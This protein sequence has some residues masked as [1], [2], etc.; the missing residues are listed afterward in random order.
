M[1]LV[2]AALS[3][4]CFPR[5]DG[6]EV[7]LYTVDPHA[8]ARYEEAA[9][10]VREEACSH[11]VFFFAR[12]GDEEGARSLV[13]RALER[14]NAG[15]LDDAHITYRFSGVPPFYSSECI[16]VTGRPVRVARGSAS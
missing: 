12:W 14:T 9:P 4:G 7:A 2:C 13:A 6:A 15:A 1:F 3:A 10:P 16:V 8:V 11:W 5:A